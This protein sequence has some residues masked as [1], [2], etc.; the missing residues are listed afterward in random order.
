MFKFFQDI[1]DKFKKT[2]PQ[3]E[4][5][6]QYKPELCFWIDRTW[7]DS[8]D[9]EKYLKLC[10]ELRVSRVGLF[11]NGVDYNP[12]K[13]PGNP[14]LPFASQEKLINAVKR[15]NA[16][17][18]KCDLTC[19]I[20][21]HPKYIEKLIEYVKPVLEIPGTRLDLDAESAWA[22]SYADDSKRRDCVKL[23]F[24]LIE[25]EKVSINDYASLQDC[26]R[27]LFVS[28]VR[29]RPQ[30]YSVGYVMR[31]G[32][33]LVTTP[34]SYYWPGTTQKNAM[35][36]KLWG[37]YSKSHQIDIGLACYKPIPSF[38]KIQ[39]IQTQVEVA[40]RYKPIELWFWQL[41]GIDS[42]YK[43]AFKK[44]FPKQ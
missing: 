4:T 7:K 2:E 25:P 42:E 9:L 30:A 27:L 28:G 15:F 36:D 38:P 13:N 21:P 33:K 37:H 17:G 12:F 5:V 10:T 32:N 43:E 34:S 1:L 20:W 41:N 18:V 8:G 16:I 44:V 24:S 19:W 3:V 22:T 31:N 35:S 26:T 39:Q 40:K 11:V 29:L 14:F 23:L 6:K